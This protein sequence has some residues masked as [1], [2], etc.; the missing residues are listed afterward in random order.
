[1]ASVSYAVRCACH[2]VELKVT[3]KPVGQSWCHCKSCAKYHQTTPVPFAMFPAEAVRVVKG[4]EHVKRISLS[5]S[6]FFKTQLGRN[7][8]KVRCS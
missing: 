8:C 7:F 5:D 1:M 6:N 2:K 3:G 4:V